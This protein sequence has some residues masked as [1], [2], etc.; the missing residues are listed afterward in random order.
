V[1]ELQLNLSYW[2]LQGNH[3]I[4]VIK[5]RCLLNTG[6]IEMKSNVK[7]NKNNRVTLERW[8]LNTSLG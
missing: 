4:R 3:E 8:S 6:L 2:A 5:D 7:G 1:E